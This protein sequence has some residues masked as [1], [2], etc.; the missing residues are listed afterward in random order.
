MGNKKKT[1]KFWF[2]P[3]FTFID[4]LKN[5]GCLSE[6]TKHP[7]ISTVKHSGFYKFQKLLTICRFFDF[8]EPFLVL[9][10]STECEGAD[11]VVLAEMKQ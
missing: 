6:D 8:D 5:K 4:F 10:G 7:E 2:H 11:Q 9:T 3:K 1:L